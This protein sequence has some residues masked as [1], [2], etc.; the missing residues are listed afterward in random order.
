MTALY[1]SGRSVVHIRIP[2]FLLKKIFLKYIR[3]SGFFAFSAISNILAKT[4]SF[5]ISLR[6][7]LICH[8]T[9][10]ETGLELVFLCLFSLFFRSKGTKFFWSGAN[11][12][13]WWITKMIWIEAKSIQR[14]IPCTCNRD[15]DKLNLIC[16]FN[17]RLKPTFSSALPASKSKTSKVAKCDPKIRLYFKVEF[18]SLIHIGWKKIILKD[19]LLRKSEMKKNRFFIEMIWRKK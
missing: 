19:W 6:S 9:G 11:P 18:K 12:I 15:L 8:K 2:T 1:F 10:P 5:L 4:Q 17:F 7:D 3:T 14:L 16:W 13:I